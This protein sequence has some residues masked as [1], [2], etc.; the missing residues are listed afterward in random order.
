MTEMEG[1]NKEAWL[2]ETEY[3][4]IILGTGLTEAIVAG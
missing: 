3:D 1:I 2:D 4:A